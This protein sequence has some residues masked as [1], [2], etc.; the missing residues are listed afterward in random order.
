M[1]QDGPFRILRR[2]EEVFIVER[3]GKEGAVPID[4]I[5]PAFLDAETPPINN[6]VAQTTLIPSDNKETIITTR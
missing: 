1:L 5:K 2:D 4:R 3:N 6:H